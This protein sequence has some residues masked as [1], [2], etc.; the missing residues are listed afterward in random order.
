MLGWT[1]SSTAPRTTTEAGEAAGP[2]TEGLLPPQPWSGTGA[3]DP[4]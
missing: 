2:S 4:G 3:S 1:A